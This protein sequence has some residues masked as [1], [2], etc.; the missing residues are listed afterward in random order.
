MTQSFLDKV[1][2]VV[3]LLGKPILLTKLILVAEYMRKA[4]NLYLNY[5]ESPEKLEEWT[6]RVE[7]LYAEYKKTVGIPF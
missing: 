3:R 1:S 5:P 6:Q 4:K 2:L 7:D